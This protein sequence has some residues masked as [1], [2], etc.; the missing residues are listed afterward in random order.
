VPT[1]TDQGFVDSTHGLEGDLV[2]P[3]D[4][5]LQ[6]GEHALFSQP[7][8][9]VAHSCILYRTGDH[10]ERLIFMSIFEFLSGMAI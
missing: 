3:Q 9:D 2:V 1:R 5:G 8:T 4:E 6:P 7:L 10:I